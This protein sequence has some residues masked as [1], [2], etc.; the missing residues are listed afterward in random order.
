MKT[1]LL[2]LL[3]C[4][5]SSVRA[6]DWL[7]EDDWPVIETA[8]S[9]STPSGWLA[10]LPTIRTELSVLRSQDDRQRRYQRAELNLNYENS[11]ADGWFTQ[12]Q[13]RG[14]YF[15]AADIQAQQQQQSYQ[16]GQWQQAWLQYSGSQCSARAGKQTL[17]WGEVEGTFAVDVVTPLDATEPLLTDYSSLRLA[18]TMLLL[19]CYQGAGRQQL[20]WQGFYIPRAGFNRWRHGGQQTSAIERRVELGGRLRFTIPYADVS[21]MLAQLQE[22]QPQL[23]L[24][25]AEWQWQAQP[26]QL[27]AASAS[28]ALGDVLLKTDVGYK[29]RQSRV[30]SAAI[31]QRSAR[32]DVAFGLEYTSYANHRLNAGWWSRRE[33]SGSGRQSVVPLWTAGWSRNYLNDDLAMSALLNH[34]PH[35]QLQTV[36]ILGQYRWNDAWQSDVAASLIDQR[37]RRFPQLTLRLKVTF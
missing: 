19:D 33:L 32:L 9:E 2:L 10:G 12:L 7:L 26:Y 17:I 23:G 27:A 24:Q 21:L 30:D 34:D 29:S 22:N 14:R 28:V 31:L 18:Q 37:E 8:S 4:V 1:R 25:N 35:Q 6:D 20:Q 15:S 11:P 16:H 36:T 3:I 13:W 5:V